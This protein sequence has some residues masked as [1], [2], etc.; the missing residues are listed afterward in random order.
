MVLRYKT[1]YRRDMR[2]IGDNLYFIRVDIPQFG[3]RD[4]PTFGWENS[5][6]Q[7]IEDNGSGKRPRSNPQRAT[8]Q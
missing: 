4:D 2:A 8:V 5:L 7:D 1:T 6:Q 3:G